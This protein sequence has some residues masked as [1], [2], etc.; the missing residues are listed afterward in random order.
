M[1]HDDERRHDAGTAAMS[2]EDPERTHLG[3]RLD[4]DDTAGD[5]AEE[6]VP[7]TYAGEEA[8]VTGRPRDAERPE[9]PVDRPRYQDEPARADRPGGG[10]APLFADDEEADLRERPRSPGER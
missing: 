6:G 5:A 4:A 3:E 1:D 9:A 7:G 10:G 2:K 8:D